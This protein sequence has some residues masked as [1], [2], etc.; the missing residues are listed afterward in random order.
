MLS[1]VQ[2]S[3]KIMLLR[4]RLELPKTSYVKFRLFHGLHAPPTCPLESMC[5][6][7]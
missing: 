1:L 4:M 6:I 2:F 7:S 5:G 3:S